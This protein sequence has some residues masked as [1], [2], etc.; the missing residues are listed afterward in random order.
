MN[1]VAVRALR[2]L[3]LCRSDTN[4]DVSFVLLFIQPAIFFV[5][6]YLSVP[7]V[8][9][10]RGLSCSMAPLWHCLSSWLCS[11]NLVSAVLSGHYLI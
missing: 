10:G 5:S 7:C 2:A 11:C 9:F 8:E 4:C 1:V 3:L 6:I